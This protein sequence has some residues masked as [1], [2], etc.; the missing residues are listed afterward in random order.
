VPPRHVGLR[1]F[2]LLLPVLGFGLVHLYDGPSTWRVP[3]T[4]GLTD[5]VYAVNVTIAML[6]MVA[7][8]GRLADG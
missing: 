3:M 8:V 4:T 5:V 7:S 2:C 6:V 1:A